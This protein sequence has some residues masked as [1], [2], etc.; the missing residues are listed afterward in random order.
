M[1]T[2]QQL[3]QEMVL[4]VLGTQHFCP[5]LSRTMSRVQ[6]SPS[7]DANDAGPAVP[8]CWPLHHTL[9]DRP[10]TCQPFGQSPAHVIADKHE[11]EATRMPLLLPFTIPVILS[12][13]GIF[14]LAPLASLAGS[15][16]PA[17]QH[18]HSQSPSYLKNNNL[19]FALRLRTS[20]NLRTFVRSPL[21]PWR[22]PSALPKSERAH[23]NRCWCCCT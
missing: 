5:S 12:N 1:A 9:G 11:P 7:R 22:S 3:R 4:D 8:L 23:G 17:R 2:A 10:Q 18:P 19:V 6:A 21:L 13:A 14:A 20:L 16:A 15:S